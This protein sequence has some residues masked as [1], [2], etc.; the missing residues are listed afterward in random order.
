MPNTHEEIQTSGPRAV[1][2][3]DLG[4][5]SDP[6]ILRVFSMC[7]LFGP[8]VP[9]PGLYRKGTEWHK[10]PLRRILNTV[11]LRVQKICK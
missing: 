6:H 5:S 7:L 1:N 8:A 4:E 2:W 11:K 9:H 10:D 3:G